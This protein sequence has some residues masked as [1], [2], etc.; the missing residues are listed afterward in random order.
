[1]YITIYAHLCVCAGAV[2]GAADVWMPRDAEG[3]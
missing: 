2:A 3:S 1:M